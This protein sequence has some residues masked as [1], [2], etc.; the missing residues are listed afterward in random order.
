M[1]LI[2]PEQN[3]LLNTKKMKKILFLIFCLT[4]LG[5]ESKK[6]MMEYDERG[7]LKQEGYLINGVKKGNWIT[8][9]SEGDTTLIEVFKSD[10][11]IIKYEYHNNIKWKKSEFKK[12]REHGDVIIFFPNGKIECQGKMSEG[13]PIGKHICY[14]EDGGI[15]RITDYNDGVNFGEF[16]QYYSNGNMNVYTK[17]LGNGL[18]EIYDTTGVLLYKIIFENFQPKDTVENN[19]FTPPLPTN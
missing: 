3:S 19:F 4:Q 7:F 14:R 12:G 6:H 8:Y 10:T 13:S 5:C 17:T 16:I 9:D 1:V 15:D 18:H 2:Q 11:L